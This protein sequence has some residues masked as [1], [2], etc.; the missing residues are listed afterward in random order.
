M[1]RIA[2]HIKNRKR[3]YIEIL[4][5]IVIVAAISIVYLY[6][7]N[8]I[9]IYLAEKYPSQALTLGQV[10]ST[11]QNNDIQSDRPIYNVSVLLLAG[12]DKG[13]TI[14]VSDRLVSSSTTNSYLKL[15]PGE[16]VLLGKD[17]LESFPGAPYYI[18]D[19]F[20]L[21]MLLFVILVFVAVAVLFGR[22]RGLT[23]ILGLGISIGVLGWYVIPQILAGA[24]PL[25]TCVIGAAVIAV[26]SL[27]LAHGF[28]KRTTIAV[29]GTMITLVISS[30]LAIFFVSGARLIGLA[31]DES[32]YLEVG[33][34]IALNLR[35]ILLGGIIIGAL[36]VLDDVTIGQSAAVH[37]LKEAN[38]SLDVKELYRRGMSI[39]REHIASLINT[40]FLAY[41]GVALPVIL[42][43]VAFQSQVPLWL[44]INGEP[45][46]EEI[47]RTAV[48]S[49]GIILAV[50]ITTLLAAYYYGKVQHGRATEERDE[51][52]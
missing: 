35:G 17:T 43:L 22:I 10:V 37:E 29:C 36:G 18:T 41:A 30:L 45:I 14:T 7:E 52:I 20:R 51:I 12:S 32:F 5:A 48:G 24:D 25:T 46:A 50:P 16:K 27:Y 13:Q 6:Q 49:I 38:Q 21:P 42:Y 3:I 9:E 4:I 39:G 47:V 11:E 8:N 44:T 26:A 23:S 33:K 15:V 40:L 2:H 34:N 1:K 19:R 31:T 28:N